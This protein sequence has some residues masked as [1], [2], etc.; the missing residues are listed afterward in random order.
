MQS[1]HIQRDSAVGHRACRQP[2]AF[3]IQAPCYTGPSSDVALNATPL[4]C[5][6]HFRPLQ[7]PNFGFLVSLAKRHHI[8]GQGSKLPFYRLCNSLNIDVS[9]GQ[10]H[11]HIS[12]TALSFDISIFHP[13]PFSLFVSISSERIISNVRP[14]SSN[15]IQQLPEHRNFHTS[16]LTGISKLLTRTIL[17]SSYSST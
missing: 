14:Q 6:K 17:S 15:Q 10:I 13:A 16:T 1:T 2:V 7:P 8:A 5:F 9:I 12:S 3:A 11:A 4:R